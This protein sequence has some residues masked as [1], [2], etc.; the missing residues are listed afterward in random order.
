MLRHNN[1]AITDEG[2][3]AV[4]LINKTGAASIKGTIIASGSVSESFTTCPADLE[5]PIGVV[6]ESG[7]ADGERCLVVMYGVVDVLLQNSTVGVYPG[8]VRISATAAGRADATN[9]GPPGGAI[10]ELGRHMREIGHTLEAVSPGGTDQLCRI[11]LHF[12]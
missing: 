10:A 5:S 2:G 9:A 6:Y 1:I 11:M 4:A 3:I 7:I 12:N 8:W